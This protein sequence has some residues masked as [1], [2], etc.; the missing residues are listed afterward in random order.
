MIDYYETGSQPIT[1][2]TLEIGTSLGIAGHNG[3][4]T[5]VIKQ[6]E[7]YEGRLSSTVL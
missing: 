5:F 3:S 1:R 6:E 4:F 7:P 2:K